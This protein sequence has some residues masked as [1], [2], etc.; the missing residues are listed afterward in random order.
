[1]LNR[2][3]VSKIDGEAETPAVPGELQTEYLIFIAEIRRP[4]IGSHIVCNIPV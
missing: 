1:M 2:G 4:E 3:K